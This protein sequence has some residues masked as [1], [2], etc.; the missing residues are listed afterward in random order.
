[1]IKLRGTHFLIAFLM[2]VLFPV[3]LGAAELPTYQKYTGPIKPGIVITKENFDTYL[4][5]LQKLLPP[6]KVKWYGM[7]VKEG[8]VTMPIVKTTYYR[9]TKGQLEATRKYAGT[10]RVGA[11]NDLL[12]WTAGVPFP[13]PKTALEVAWNCYPSISRSSAHDDLLFFSKFLL[14]KNVQYEKQFT[15]DLFDRK[16]RGRADIHPLGNMPDFTESGISFKESIVILEPN[17]VKGFIQLRIRYWEM[18]KADECYAYIPAIRRVRRLTGADLTDP[19][20]GTDCVPDDFEVWRQKLD[21]RMKIRVL[22]HRD[23]LV[24]RAYVG[25]ENKPAYDYEK[26]GPCFPV[27]WEIR[28]MWVLEIMLN[29]PDYVYSKRIIYVDAVPVDQGGSCLLYWGEQY[30]QKGRLW[31]ANGQGAPGGNKEGFKCLFN[32]MYM[33]YQTDH[34]TVMDGYPAYVKGFDQ[35]FPLKEEDAFSIKG[36]L[37]RAR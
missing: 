22:E 37:K 27:E 11:N 29:D 15:W 4:P 19:L 13:E 33:N 21:P 14:F 26:H 12:N 28:P 31:K 24:P 9:V 10:A 20:L 3:F 25:L 1:M 34:Y 32:W 2:G 35:A 18:G 8:L 7:G 16:Y 23:F 6:S 36:L 17:E 5:E 30:D